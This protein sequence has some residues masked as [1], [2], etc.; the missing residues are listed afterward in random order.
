VN[1]LSGALECN[2]V[3]ANK[4]LYSI[5]FSTK[6]GLEQERRSAHKCRGGNLEMDHEEAVVAASP[7]LA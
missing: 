7:T 2:E 3:G 4:Y 6:V 5:A 1:L